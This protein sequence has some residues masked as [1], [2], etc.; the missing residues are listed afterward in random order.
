M[1]H[2]CSLGPD[3]NPIFLGSR[4]FLVLTIRVEVWVLLVWFLSNYAVL[5]VK[6][7]LKSDAECES[8]TEQN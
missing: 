7:W 6:I 2:I 4:G 3:K 8:K 1:I 5:C